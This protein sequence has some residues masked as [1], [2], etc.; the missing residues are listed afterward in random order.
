MMRKAIIKF[1]EGLKTKGT[2]HNII[3]CSDAG[4]AGIRVPNGFT[5]WDCTRYDVAIGDL[6]EDG[7]FS[8]PETGLRAAYIPS[9]E[10]EIVVLKNRVDELEKLKEQV[11]EMSVM[12]AQVK[13]ESAK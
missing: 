12:M 2:V 7:V 6:W 13:S 8:K 9:A 5:L 4:L 3:E 10:E 1:D 11:A